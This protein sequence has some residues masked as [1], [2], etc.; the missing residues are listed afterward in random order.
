MPC[1]EAQQQIELEIDQPHF[2][3]LDG[4]DGVVPLGHV[5]VAVEGE[6]GDIKAGQG[7]AVVGDGG[8]FKGRRDA[9]GHGLAGHLTGGVGPGGLP[10]SLGVVL[11]V[12]EEPL[13]L[14]LGGEALCLHSGRGRDARADNGS[15]VLMA[16][17]LVELERRD[18]FFHGVLETHVVAEVGQTHNGEPLDSLELFHPESIELLTKGELIRKDR[19]GVLFIDIFY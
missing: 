12:V 5:E 1:R 19:L 9:L 10:K 15:D 4:G 2:H 14:G 7:E 8:Q 16:F 18:C 6:L 17:L 11:G 13:D 3:Q